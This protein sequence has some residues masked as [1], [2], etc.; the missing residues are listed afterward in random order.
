MVQSDPLLHEALAGQLRIRWLDA[1]RGSRADAV[2]KPV[3][4]RHHLHPELAQETTVKLAGSRE[5]AH[6][7]DHMRH[8]VDFNGHRSRLQAIL[9]DRR[10]SDPIINSSGPSSGDALCIPTSCSIEIQL[11]NAISSRNS[12]ERRFFGKF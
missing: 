2:E 7:Q 3:I 5:V 9:I 11:Y 8:S 1:D 12:V 10:I 6:R 4:V